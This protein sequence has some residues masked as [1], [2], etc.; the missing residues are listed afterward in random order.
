MR[1]PTEIATSDKEN[2]TPAVILAERRAAEAEKK[3]GKAVSRSVSMPKDSRLAG[4][5]R[6]RKRVA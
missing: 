4:F 5:F 3:A 2:T 6:R 1:P